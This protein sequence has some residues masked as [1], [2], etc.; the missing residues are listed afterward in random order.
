[1]AGGDGYLYALDAATGAVDWKS[2]IA[3]PS[4][5]VNDYY[6]WSSPTVVNGNIYVGVASN[7]DSPLVAAGLKEYSQATGA[8]ENSTTPIQGTRPSRVSEQRW[9]AS[10]RAARVRHHGNGLAATPVSVVRLSVDVA[11]GRLASADHRARTRLGLWRVAH[12]VHG[13]HWRRVDP[14]GRRLQ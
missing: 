11:T 5:T 14:D 12:A 6:D 3:I 1:V 10:C 2:V 7:C 4:T 8:L 13:D 9:V